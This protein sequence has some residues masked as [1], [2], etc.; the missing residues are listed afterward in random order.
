MSTRAIN[1]ECTLRHE[2]NMTI[3]V[4][5][6]TINYSKY[7][8]HSIVIKKMKIKAIQINRLLNKNNVRTVGFQCRVV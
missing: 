3:D 1:C 7:R 8:M 5:L 6:V 2:D 4:F